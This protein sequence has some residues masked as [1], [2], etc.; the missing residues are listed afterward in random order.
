MPE[1]DFT[2]LT[3]SVMRRRFDELYQMLYGRT[4]PESPVEFVNFRVRASLPVRLLEIPR[5]NGRGDL[6][7]N[8]VKGERLAYSGLA[9]DMIPFTVYDRY[10]LSPGAAFAGPA[11]IEE[12]ESTLIVDE[13]AQA[14]VD[15]FGFLWVERT[16][17]SERT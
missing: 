17:E 16:T 2:S 13:Q 9:S 11:I 8:A 5:L 14:R 7:A 6:L 1:S 12:R 4:Y 10:R 15:E 3:P